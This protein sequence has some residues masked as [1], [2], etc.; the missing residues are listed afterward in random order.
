MSHFLR[1]LSSS[2]ILS[3][4]LSFLGTTLAATANQQAIQITKSPNPSEV[5]ITQ[6][7][8]K[9]C[10]ALALQRNKPKDIV[11]KFGKVIEDSGRQ[12]EVKPFNTDLMS[13]YVSENIFVGSPPYPADR[14]HFIPNS[15]VK[16]SMTALQ[17][18]FGDYVRHLRKVEAFRG[19][20]TFNQRHARTPYRASFYFKPISI[21]P[22]YCE[23]T[24]AYYTIDHEPANNQNISQINITKIDVG[25]VKID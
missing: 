25:L 6:D 2:L 8:K 7:I 3:I 18:E 13:V 12:Y 20:E 10:I 23:I 11:A 17:Q 14:V 5:H 22:K 4:L 1:E 15:Q 19:D 21:W 24:V 16:I 9:A